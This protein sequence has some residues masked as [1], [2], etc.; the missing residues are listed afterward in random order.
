ML[1]PGR[2]ATALLFLAA[3]AGDVKFVMDRPR[4]GQ[5]AERTWAQGTGRACGGTESARVLTTIMAPDQCAIVHLC[6]WDWLG[7]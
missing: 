6:S 2:S 3:T 7:G 4:A 5:A 1:G